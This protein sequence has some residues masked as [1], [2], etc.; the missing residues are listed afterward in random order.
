MSTMALTGVSISDVVDK[1]R[2]LS[3]EK[4]L[5]QM[6]PMYPVSTDTGGV[7]KNFSVAKPL[8]YQDYACMPIPYE[9][10]NFAPGDKKTIRLKIDDFLNSFSDVAPKYTF[11]RACPLLIFSC[12]SDWLATGLI[13]FEWSPYISSTMDNIVA[14]GTFERTLET[15]MQVPLVQKHS[16]RLGQN[17]VFAFPLPWIHEDAAFHFKGGSGIPTIAEPDYWPVLN[18]Y[19]LIPMLF[20]TGTSQTVDIEVYLGWYDVGFGGFIGITRDQ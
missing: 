17:S 1:F 9:Y 20:P 5:S 13:G 16:Y 4:P 19:E 8:V 11:G 3:L 6:R 18:I 7:V 2:Q 15:F 14:G 12:T 10:Y